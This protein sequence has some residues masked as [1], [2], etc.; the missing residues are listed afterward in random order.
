MAATVS[1]RTNFEIISDYNKVE[2]R[3]FALNDPNLCDPS[4]ATALLDGEYVSLN[5]SRKLVR[6]ADISQA[7]GTV[8]TEPGSFCALVWLAEKGRSDVM[9]N[10][11]NKG[12]VVFLGEFEAQTRLFDAAAGSGITG[13]NQPLKVAV[14]ADASGNKYSGL[15]RHGG[16][17]DT[18]PVAGYVTRLPGSDGYLWYRKGTRNFGGT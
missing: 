13:M 8:G 2:R 5:D 4:L 6:T 12:P 18:D 1:Q 15:I 3:D 14:I 11:E 17:S 10:A 7:A 9:A 16:H